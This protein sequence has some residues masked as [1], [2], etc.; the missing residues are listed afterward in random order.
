[1]IF[2]STPPHNTDPKPYRSGS[3]IR[4]AEPNGIIRNYRPRPEFDQPRAHDA[5]PILVEFRRSSPFDVADAAARE[6]AWLRAPAAPAVAA[7]PAQIDHARR[8][9]IR[10]AGWSA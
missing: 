1:M 5:N 3:G 2:A 7:T 10:L 8:V 4:A 6:A 9:L